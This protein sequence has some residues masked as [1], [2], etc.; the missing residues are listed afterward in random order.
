MSMPEESTTNAV[1][2]AITN[3]ITDDASTKENVSTK[4]VLVDE[5][6]INGYAPAPKKRRIVWSVELHE[7]FV[8]AVTQLG[9]HKAEP[10]RILEVMNIPDLTIENVASHL[11]KFKNF[12]KRSNAE[13]R[14]QNG[15]EALVASEQFPLEML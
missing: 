3:G 10:K 14:Q 6:K 7:H 8:R 5:S 4:E 15:I 2:R 1:M 13:A 12:V 11:Q 9:L